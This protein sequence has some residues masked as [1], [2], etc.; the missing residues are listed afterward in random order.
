M[1]KKMT[2]LL[3]AIMII[4]SNFVPYVVVAKEAHETISDSAIVSGVTDNNNGKSKL[5]ITFEKKVAEKSVNPKLNKNGTFEAKEAGQVD[6]DLKRYG[7]LGIAKYFHIFANKAKLTAD[8]AGNLAVGDLDAQSNFGT[9]IKEGKLNT[10]ISYIQNAGYI[11]SSSFVS[12]NENRKNKAVFGEKVNLTLVDNGNKVAANGN[13]LDHLTKD[14][15]YQDKNGSKY[16]DFEK[17]FQ[18]LKESSDKLASNLQTDGVEK[19]FN[20]ENNRY[21][22]VSKVKSSKL[23][24]AVLTKTDEDGKP[25]DNVEFALYKKG[26]NK[27]IS[28]HKTSNGKIIVN[29]LEKGDY[30]FKEISTLQGYILNTNNH[31]FSITDKNI[32]S[33]KTIYLDLTKEELEKDRPITIKGIKKN[34]PNIVINVD[35]KNA[36]TINIGAEIKL[37]YTDGTDRNNHETEDF[38]DAKV[39]WNFK[40]RAINQVININRARFQGSIL[41]VGNTINVGQNVDG[42]II[43]DTVNI[44]GGESHRWDFQEEYESEKENVELTVVNKKQPEEIEKISISVEKKWVGKIGDSVT[45]QLKAEGSETILQEYELKKSEGWKHTFTGLRKYA[46]DGSPI[47]YKVEEKDV[48]QGY[49]VHYETDPTGTLI[50]KNVQDKIKVK[51]TKAWEDVTGEHPTIKLQLLKNG[52]NEG[53]PIELTNGTTTHTWTDLDKMDSQGNEYIYTVKEVGEMANSIQLEGDWYKVTYGGN[54]QNG[55]TVTNKKF[56]SWTPMIPPTRTIKVTKEWK[57]SSG[58]NL[59]EAPIEKIK[60]ELYKDGNP[61]GKKLEL[62]KDNNWSGEFKNL[63]V[64]NGLGSTDYYKYTVKEVGE[65]GNAIKFDGKQYKVVYGGSMKEGFT[66][67]N[68]KEAPPTPPNKTVPKTEDRTN[69]FLYAWLMFVSGSLLVLLGIRKRQQQ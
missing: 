62:T 11:Q 24:T 15:I 32:G 51:V 35:T 17:E 20:D 49:T 53:S 54:I 29:N 57:D 30:Y 33:P 56:P 68:E 67:T 27:P 4:L 60:V 45:V 58:N 59:S 16:I 65:D 64:G 26:E 40:N 2:T 31:N 28:K 34:G 46:A 3:L 55:L 50:I 43:A 69:P 6:T 10:D 23:G 61:T 12:S 19:N 63:A 52:Q 9:R 13:K 41:A 5:G 48:P 44:I 39:L 25:L 37:Q 1:K 66:I 36:Q 22:D 47:K 42:C 18:L 8:T 38:S 21:F 14:E 7:L